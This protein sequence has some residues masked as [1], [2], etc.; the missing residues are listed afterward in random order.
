M[1]FISHFDVI[2]SKDPHIV[3][4]PA[5]TNIGKKSFITSLASLNFGLFFT[6]SSFCLKISLEDNSMNLA[7]AFYLVLI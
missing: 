6:L 3:F 1:G 7:N 4:L 2:R 5:E